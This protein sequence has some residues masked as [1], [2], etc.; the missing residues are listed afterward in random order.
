MLE[1]SPLS[2]PSWEL[3]PFL[4][5]RKHHYFQNVIALAIVST[6]ALILW[7][8]Y[9]LNVSSSSFLQTTLQQ[10]LADNQIDDLVVMVKGGYDTRHRLPYALS[11]LPKNI[12]TFVIADYDGEVQDTDGITY[13]VYDVIKR[14]EYTLRKGNSKQL[15]SPAW[16]FYR[17]M[18][19]DKNNGVVRQSELD[20]HEGW[21]LDATKYLPALELALQ[22]YPSKRWFYIA[23]DDTYTHFPSLLDLIQWANIKLPLHAPLYLGKFTT[24]KDPWAHGGSGV[25]LNRNSLVLLFH[26][27]NSEIVWKSM[28]QPPSQYGDLNLGAALGAAGVQAWVPSA[29]YFNGEPMANTRLRADR[30][31]Q[32]IATFHHADEEEM[33]HIHTQIQAA[34]KM[35]KVMTWLD[36]WLWDGPHNSSNAQLREGWNY[37][38]RFGLPEELDLGQTT[39]S[40]DCHKA[41]ESSKGCLAWT[42]IDS[43]C[44]G[45]PWF[46]VGHE[47]SRAISG[48]LME[49]VEKALQ[50]GGCGP[51]NP[52]MRNGLEGVSIVA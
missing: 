23:D 28:E 11:Y 27:K 18:Q 15:D 51:Q 33:I 34:G 10:V 20:F 43:N 13:P 12:D 16:Q 6:F 45:A 30:L 32:P 35:D 8:R 36:P 5:R 22:L 21:N 7:Y 14:L 44:R 38:T 50:D 26:D 25:L 52:K 49:Q 29:L 41:C 19:R 48:V 46:G 3:Q 39:T 47:D 1:L 24:V 9:T 4:R 40:E 42:L 31:C 2:Q 37:I 17:A